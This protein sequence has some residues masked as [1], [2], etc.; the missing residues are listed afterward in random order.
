MFE[1]KWK[2][3]EISRFK[4]TKHRRPQ[5]S[6]HD[7]KFDHFDINYWNLN[8]VHRLYGSK[9]SISINFDICLLVLWDSVLVCRIY[10]LKI[11]WE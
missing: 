7:T 10:A 9:S 11:F 6:S 5:K 8:K 4:N 1:G 2:V 3:R